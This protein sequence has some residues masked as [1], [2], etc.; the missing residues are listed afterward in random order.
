MPEGEEPPPRGVKTMAAVRWVIV[1]AAAVLAAFMWLSYARTQLSTAKPGEGA[2]APKYHCPMH[3]QIVSDE[4]GECPICHMNLEPIAGGRAAPVGVVP[5]GGASPATARDA[6]SDGDAGAGL[7]CPMHP[8]VHSP[9]PGRCPIC[10]MPLEPADAGAAADAGATAPGSIPPGTTPV[11]LALD[12]IQ[13][14]GVR[15][16]VAE[17]RALAA[18]LRVTAIVMPPEQGVERGPCP[19]A[20]LRRGDARRPDRRGGSR[21]A[22]H[23]LGLQPGDPPGAER[24]PR[25]EPVDRRRR[26]L[27]DILGPA[28]ARAPRDGARRDRARRRRSGRRS[29]RSPS[30]RRAADSSPRRTSSSART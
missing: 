29:A 20:G 9:T 23:A 19:H 10:K 13:S 4:P 1:I 26:S 17:D 6:G 2:T 12:R 3:P 7:T 8:E 30:R 16:A 22:A 14:I 27:I 11:K 15:T 28:E 24:A 5:A 18:N 21:R 25:D